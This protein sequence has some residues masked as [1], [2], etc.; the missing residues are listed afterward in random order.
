[1]TDTDADKAAIIALDAIWSKAASSGDLETVVNIYAP[2]GSLVW[3]GQEAVHGSAAIRTAWA[4]MM[5]TPGLSLNFTAER[6]DIAA[7]GDLAVD[8]GRV[9][10]GQ[11]TDKGHESLVG[12]YVVAWTKR[13]GEWKVL[14]DSYNTNS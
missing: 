10:F 11:D 1:M 7:S 3:P 4:A 13:S 14:Y 12:K 6:I 9:D 2:D 5:K 8:F